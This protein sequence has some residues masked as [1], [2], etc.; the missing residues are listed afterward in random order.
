MDYKLVMTRAHNSE[1]SFSSKFKGKIKFASP[2]Q[3]NYFYQYFQP[4]SPLSGPTEEAKN[5]RFHRLEHKA[6]IIP[7][8][9]E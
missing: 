3:L 6:F 7:L 1:F 9:L 8:K 2:F 5:C 4:L